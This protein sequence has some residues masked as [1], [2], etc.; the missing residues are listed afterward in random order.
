MNFLNLHKIIFR[1]LKIIFFKDKPEKVRIRTPNELNIRKQEFIKI[2]N[3]LDQNRIRFFLQGGI[4][5]GAIRNGG[6]IPWDWDVEISVY[7]NEVFNKIDILILELRKSGFKID[8]YS[9][10][11]NNLK[12]DFIGK[13]PKKTTHYT[14]LGWQHDKDKMVFWRNNF[15]VPD[16]FFNKLEKIKL[17]NRYFYAP[18]DPKKYLKYQYGNWEIPIQTSDKTVYL[19]RKFSGISI[20]EILIKKIIKKLNI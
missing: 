10:S 1:K 11:I 2:C 8:K 12:I 6:F 17:F 4:L 14:I 20:I 18:Y 3:I 15:S 19:T 16:F 13:L 9:K 7:S 5:L